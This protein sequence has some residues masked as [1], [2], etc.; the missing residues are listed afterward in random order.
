[1]DWVRRMFGGWRAKGQGRVRRVIVVGLEGLDPALVEE[2][3]EQGL[4]HN[5][6][7]LA[8]RRHVCAARRDRV[9]ALAVLGRGSRSGHS[10]GGALSPVARQFGKSCRKRYDG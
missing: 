3:L 2:Y 5:L 4:L 6:A 7:L 9:A 10:D 1:M 8:R